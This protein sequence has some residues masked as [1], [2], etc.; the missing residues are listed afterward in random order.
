M[1]EKGSVEGMGQEKR[2]VPG[3]YNGGRTVT[4]IKAVVR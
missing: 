4:L 2:S 1:H 3:V